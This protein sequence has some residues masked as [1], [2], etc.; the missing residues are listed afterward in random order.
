MET[1]IDPVPETLCVK[2]FQNIRWKRRMQLQ[3]S[4]V[5]RNRQNRT[6]IVRAGCKMLPHGVVRHGGLPGAPQI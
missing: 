5:T 6:W 3:R 4:D 1:R 2:V